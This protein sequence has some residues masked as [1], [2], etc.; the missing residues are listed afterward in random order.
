MSAPRRLLLASRVRPFSLREISQRSKC[1][2]MIEGDCTTLVNPINGDAKAFLLDR[3]FLLHR[4]CCFRLR[5]VFAGRS[6]NSFD[7][8]SE[9]Y[10]HNDQI[11]E[12]TGPAIA[13]SIKNEHNVSVFVMGSPGTGKTHTLV[14]T[15]DDPGLIPRTL[16]LLFACVLYCLSAT[17]WLVHPVF[18]RYVENLNSGL[19]ENFDH[20]THLFGK[21][22]DV[23]A[24]KW[25]DLLSSKHVTGGMPLKTDTLYGAYVSGLTKHKLATLDDCEGFLA[26]VISASQSFGPSFHAIVTFD[27]VR[28][29]QANP[30]AMRYTKVHLVR[31][32]PSVGE[33]SLIAQASKAPLP[34]DKA[35]TAWSSVMLALASATPGRTTVVPSRESVMT[36][37]LHDSMVLLLTPFPQ[38]SLLHHPRLLHA[39]P[40]L[41]ARCHPPTCNTKI[42]PTPSA[43]SFVQKVNLF[44]FFYQRSLLIRPFPGNTDASSIR[45]DPLLLRPDL[46]GE[47]VPAAGGGWRWAYV[48][49]C[50][51]L[52]ETMR[53]LLTVY[54][55]FAK[56]DGTVSSSVPNILASP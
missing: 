39:P 35:M 32:S 14:G 51:A 26:S 25:R 40:L 16:E 20:T 4:K 43:A 13:S 46:A 19:E 42:L 37:L 30:T 6:Y 54:R 7:P 41:S 18:L 56:P 48:R 47:W 44:I 12:D 10:I 2:I 3:C 9:A 29:P 38:L 27:I 17:R 33:A 23:G 53:A 1:S 34:K 50:A 49:A 8:Q 31:L 36:R 52:R 15:Q 5:D 45:P 24:E 11:F 22:Y 21:V 28:V 55:Y